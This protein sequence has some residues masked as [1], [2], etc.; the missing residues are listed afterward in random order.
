[1]YRHRNSSIYAWSPV[2]LGFLATLHVCTDSTSWYM[3]IVLV[4]SVWCVV[5]V[6]AFSVLV[7]GVG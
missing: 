6:G 7:V 3:Y 4:L 5:Q 1:M 2:Q